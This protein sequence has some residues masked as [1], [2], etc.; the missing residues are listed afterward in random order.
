M[1]THIHIH[2][3]LVLQYAKRFESMTKKKWFIGNNL[4]GKLDVSVL[5]PFSFLSMQYCIGY[6]ISIDNKTSTVLNK[7]ITE[8]HVCMWMCMCVLTDSLCARQLSIWSIACW[9]SFWAFCSS[10]KRTI[11]NINNNNLKNRNMSVKYLPC[12]ATLKS[13]TKYCTNR[14]KQ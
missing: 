2:I 6:H 10:R 14:C 11:T 3:H 5:R 9:P 8:L 13:V 12:S 7:Y 1:R 4:V